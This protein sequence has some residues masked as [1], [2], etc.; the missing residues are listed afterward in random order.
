MNPGDRY[1]TLTFNIWEEDGMF[2][3]ECLE[4]G[5]AT[6]GDAFSQVRERLFDA[7]ELHVSTLE[8]IG[9]RPRVF[10][11]KG[12]TC[13]VIG[14]SVNRK[15]EECLTNLDKWWEGVC[16]LMKRD[17][18]RSKGAY[19]IHDQ[20]IGEDYGEPTEACLDAMMTM[21]QSEGILLDPV[22]SGKVFSGLLDHAQ[23]G[24]WKAG[25]NVLFLHS[26]GTPAIFA[27]HDPI[28]A[29]LRKRGVVI[30]P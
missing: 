29:H 22:Y 23:A 30:A 16:H 27:Y 13:P 20:F 19:E 7:I 4:L 9:E 6:C 5:T 26:G 10:R 18:Q 17:P 8:E 28:E 12:I 24:R 15:K 14:I 1:I 25:Q 3:G 21:A 2:A 11:E